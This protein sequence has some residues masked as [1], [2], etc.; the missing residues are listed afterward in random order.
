MTTTHERDLARDNAL[1]L[2]APATADIAP[3]RTNRSAQLS[4]PALPMIS[5]ILMRKASGAGAADPEHAVAAAGGSAGQMLPE[6][7]RAKFESSLGTD[8]SSVRVHTGDDS[9]KAASAVGAHAY[10]MGND[11]HFAAGQ[12]DPHS[13]S[14]QE[15]IAHEVAHTVQQRGGSP[16]RQ[17]K[18][19]ISSAGDAHELEADRAAVAMVTGAP[20]MLSTSGILVARKDNPTPSNS[21]NQG[22]LKW[23]NGT[24]LQEDE[25]TQ[26]ASKHAGLLGA[27]GAL[28]ARCA[29]WC[30]VSVPSI[31]ELCYGAK[32]TKIQQEID[33]DLRIREGCIAHLESQIE[34][35]RDKKEL[36]AKEQAALAEYCDQLENTEKPQLA[37]KL[38]QK[39]G[40][41]VK[42]HEYATSTVGAGASA[43]SEF[44]SI[45][46]PINSCTQTINP[47][48][49]NDMG[50]AASKIEAGVSAINFL[51][52][53]CDRSQFSAFEANPNLETCQAWGDKVGSLFA[54]A[55]GLAAMLP[56]GL[57]EVYAGVLNTPQRVISAFG[58]VVKTYYA[59]VDFMSKDDC[60]GKQEMPKGGTSSTCKNT[61]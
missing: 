25:A 50:E 17:N 57:D 14:G 2:P 58:S 36:T 32:I 13:S 29:A 12:Y 22:D 28:A 48:V 60:A 56:P 61:H 9:A 54:S 11:I 45:A 8:L 53:M 26:F 27:A 24:A 5:G 38:A 42:L 44:T 31:V 16:A 19:S 59:N 10:A 21:Y 20:A 34:F 35:L 37:A 49:F 47:A 43:L 6:Q 7:L 33:A 46:G 40:A 30:G 18:L 1:D 3:G 51:G 23:E 4:A 55:S 39:A 15:L 41:P 52:E